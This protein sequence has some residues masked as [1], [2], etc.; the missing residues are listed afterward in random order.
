MRPIVYSACP[1][2]RAIKWPWA[3]RKCDFAPLAA[4]RSVLDGDAGDV[5]ALQ[6]PA[7]RLGLV[8]VEAGKAGAKQLLVAFGDDRLSERIGVS[9]QAAGL[10]A[11]RVDALPGL[12]FT[13]QCADLNDPSGAGGDRLDGAGLLNGLRLWAGGR[14]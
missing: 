10:I 12:A 1:P 5:R 14:I 3:R 4:C 7:Y 11:R 8:V 2:G 9:E 6:C 13:F